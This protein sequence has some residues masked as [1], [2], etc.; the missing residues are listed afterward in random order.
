MIGVPS[1]EG[2][3]ETVGI[4]VRRVNDFVE[5]LQLPSR[6]EYWHAWRNVARDVWMAAQSVRALSFLT[7]RPLVLL[8]WL[9]LQRV[10]I[11]LKFLFR[12]L[13]Q[14][15]YVSLWKGLEQ[16]KW[17]ARRLVAWQ[18]SLTSTQIKMEL[19]AVIILLLLF[20]LRR[21]IQKQGYVQRVSR[22]YQTKKR[23]A[24][25][26]SDVVC[27]PCILS[28]VVPDC[29]HCVCLQELLLMNC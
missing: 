12:H 5:Y 2:F 17:C 19:S 25:K 4:A 27:L 16:A 1:R 7:L 13:F 29:E 23:Y 15:L 9:V 28:V 11:C 26:V 21:Y 18:Y 8:L 20:S 10:Y 24:I 14:G 3:S 6:T 22:W